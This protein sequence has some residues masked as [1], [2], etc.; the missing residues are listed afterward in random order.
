MKEKGEA[1]KSERATF[2]RSTIFPSNLVIVLEFS[3]E[4]LDASFPSFMSLGT[5]ECSTG[6]EFDLSGAS[7]K[8]FR[9]P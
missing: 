3:P 9:G 6:K 7:Q 4:V 2:G 8:T 5:N 1:L